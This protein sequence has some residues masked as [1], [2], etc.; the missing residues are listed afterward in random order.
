MTVRKSRANVRNSRSA[1]LEKAP[2]GEQGR[3]IRG[4]GAAKSKAVFDYFGSPKHQAS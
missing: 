3:I 4:T 1:G 2:L